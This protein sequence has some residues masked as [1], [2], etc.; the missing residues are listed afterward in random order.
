MRVK[1]KWNVKGRDR[2]MA[3]VGGAAAFILWR[4]AQ[5]GLL[6]LENE[7]FQTDTRAQ[8]LDVIGEFLAF[9]VHLADRLKA[10]QLE[11]DERTEFITS[12]ARHL[13]DYMQ[14]NRTDAQGKGEYRKALIDLL[15]E[16]AA[17]YADFNMPEGEPGYAMRRYFGENVRAVMGK[18]ENQWITD[19]VMEIEVPETLPPLKKALRELFAVEQQA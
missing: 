12:L 13:A 9:L 15:N 18:K 10:A 19:Q 17:D 5:Q 7:G 14:E 16:R 1:S 8:R 3:E 4:I 11:L 2:G 6:N